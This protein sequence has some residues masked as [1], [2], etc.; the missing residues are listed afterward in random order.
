M[1]GMAWIVSTGLVGL[2]FLAAAVMDAVAPERRRKFIAGYGG[3]MICNVV[4]TW[5]AGFMPV[6]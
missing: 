1:F 4:L 2:L 3:A 5:G 6:W